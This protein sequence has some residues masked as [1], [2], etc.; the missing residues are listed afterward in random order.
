MTSQCA[1]AVSRIGESYI[2]MAR[3]TAHMSEMRRI[4]D[5]KRQE[6]AAAR[7]R[8]AAISTVNEPKLKEPKISGNDDQRC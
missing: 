7:H 4:D 2:I 3:G 6:R 8:Y 5:I 1:G